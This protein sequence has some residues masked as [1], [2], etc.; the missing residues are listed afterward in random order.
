MIVYAFVVEE[1]VLSMFLAGIGPGILLASFFIIFSIIYV[2]FFNKEVVN[3][4][5]TLEEKIKYTKR[6]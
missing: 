3:V 4:K 1:S 6:G 2:K 5:S